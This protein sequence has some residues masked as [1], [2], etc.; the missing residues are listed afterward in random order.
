[1]YPP[2]SRNTATPLQAHL[3]GDLVRDHPRGQRDDCPG[4]RHL[5]EHVE[6][7]P[8]DDELGQAQDDECDRQARYG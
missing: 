1:M 5:R 8:D 7:E 4:A 3:R 2:I 6:R